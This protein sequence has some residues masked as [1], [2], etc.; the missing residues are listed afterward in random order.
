M[1]VTPVTLQPESATTKIASLSLRRETKPEELSGAVIFFVPIRHNICAYDH[2]RILRKCGDHLRIWGGWGLWVGVRGVFEP[3][4]G[5]VCARASARESICSK[6][7]FTKGTVSD[8]PARFTKGTVEFLPT[9]HYDFSIGKSQ[10][11]TPNLK[12][13]APAARHNF[14]FAWVIFQ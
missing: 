4:S 12:K 10:K 7:R 3:R 2:L 5:L 6:T 1:V 11:K 8:L 14:A 13:I 9:L